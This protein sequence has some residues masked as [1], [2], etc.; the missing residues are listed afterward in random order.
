MPKKT[1]VR[2]PYGGEPFS[3]AYIPPQ[4]LNTLPSDF[5]L[6]WKAA[7]TEEEMRCRLKDVMDLFGD[8][9]PV[10]RMS[11]EELK[12]AGNWL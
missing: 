2:D 4:I 10:E 9:V 1:T 3:D 7:A 6:Q 12:E 11:M 8:E 5:L